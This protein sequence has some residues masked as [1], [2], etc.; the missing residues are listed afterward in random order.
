MLP[1]VH[2]HQKLT[3]SQSHS[4][5]SWYLEQHNPAE[6]DT[7]LKDNPNGPLSGILLGDAYAYYS[8]KAT[9]IASDKMA[10]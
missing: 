5:G 4:D 2:N 3:D 6:Q 8:L 10:F 1:L 9:Y 7:S